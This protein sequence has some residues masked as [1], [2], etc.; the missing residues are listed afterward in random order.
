MASVNQLVNAERILAGVSVVCI[1]III[2][3]RRSAVLLPDT[4]FFPETFL[5]KC[6]KPYL[7]FANQNLA[8][9]LMVGGGH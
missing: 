2:V 3:Q 7:D 6:S 5:M 1:T 8:K 9:K 4:V